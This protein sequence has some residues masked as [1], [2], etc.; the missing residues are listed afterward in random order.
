MFPMYTVTLGQETIYFNGI[1]SF[2]AI[3]LPIM[4]IILKLSMATDRVRRR[5]ISNIRF[6]LLFRLITTNERRTNCYII[7]DN[8]G[9][10]I[11]FL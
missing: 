10:Y 9:T 4:M 7:V 11:V 5:F 8:V 6:I 1:I 2:S 3:I